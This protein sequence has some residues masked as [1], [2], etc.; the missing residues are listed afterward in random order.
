MACFGKVIWKT[1]KFFLGGPSG[2][3]GRSIT[4]IV[5]FMDHSIIHVMNAQYFE[6][7]FVTVHIN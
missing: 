6:I 1:M 3:F 7:R 4:P 2:R 5:A